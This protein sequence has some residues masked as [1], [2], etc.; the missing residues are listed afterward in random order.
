[1]KTYK[2][3]PY[4]GTLVINPKDSVQDKIT[5]YFDVINQENADGWELVTIAPVNVTVKRGGLKTKNDVYYA[6]IFQKEV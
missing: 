5:A 3:V 4:I 1:M 2:V 6:F